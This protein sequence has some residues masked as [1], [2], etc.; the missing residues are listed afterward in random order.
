MRIEGLPEGW[1]FVFPPAGGLKSIPGLLIAVAATAGLA[2]GI[3]QA[4]APWVFP[5]AVAAFGLIPIVAILWSAAGEVRVLLTPRGVR[6]TYA[7]LGIR[8][9][10]HAQPGEVLEAGISAM[11]H[12]GQGSPA[13]GIVLRRRN[14]GPLW[15]LAML[16]GKGE[17]EWVASEL[18]RRLPG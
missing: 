15:V 11:T 8:R 10:W 17:A 18:N 12:G 5:L 4:G 16:T 7:V 6:L 13:Y 1:A 14:A 2:W 3:R 9:S